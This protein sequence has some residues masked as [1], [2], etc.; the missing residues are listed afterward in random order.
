MHTS[1]LT[2]FASILSALASPPS[3]PNTRALAQRRRRARERGEVT[4][5]LGDEHP[6][7]SPTPT[8]NARALAQRLRRARE[9]AQA[10]AIRDDDVCPPLQVS[11]P[12]CVCPRLCDH[13]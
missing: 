1:L 5:I 10:A 6:P 13:P 3:T 4:T 11:D 8:P 12:D 2:I 7:A 9:R